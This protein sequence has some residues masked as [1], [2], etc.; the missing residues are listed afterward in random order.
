MFGWQPWWY[1]SHR[2]CEHPE[3]LRSL[4]VQPC[5]AKHGS[6]PSRQLPVWGCQST[7]VLFGC[8]CPGNIL[9]GLDC[10][11]K[12]WAGTW[13][14][15]NSFSVVRSLVKDLQNS[16]WETPLLLLGNC[17]D[18]GLSSLKIPFLYN[19]LF[20]LFSSAVPP[21]A[22]SSI[23]AQILE[24]YCLFRRQSE[25]FFG[26]CRTMATAKNVRGVFGMRWPREWTKQASCY[27]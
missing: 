11:S 12:W 23:V 5:P 10:I 21:A 13:I 7:E 22:K 3:A 16:V 25:L 8:L 15:V 26:I 24:I 4:S 2:G 19:L 1:S 20:F 14:G 9:M 6:H 27:K 17:R 18:V